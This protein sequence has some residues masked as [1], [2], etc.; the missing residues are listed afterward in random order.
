MIK[1]LI[2]SVI[3][4]YKYT[5]K[6]I[7]VWIATIVGFTIYKGY[8]LG[9]TNSMMPSQNNAFSNWSLRR[10]YVDKGLYSLLHLNIVSIMMATSLLLVPMI[11]Y[12]FIVK[13]KIILDKG[14]GTYLS[15]SF[16]FVLS[17]YTFM[18][19]DTP[20]NYYASRYFLFILVPLIVIL[21]IIILSKIKSKLIILLVLII[22]FSFN[23]TYDY[24]LY[25]K[26]VFQNGFGMAQ[27]I[28]NEI[29]DGSITFLA[30]DIFS[31]RLLVQ[32]LRYL[33][34]LDV[35]YLGKK[36]KDNLK[37]IKNK[38]ELY[39]KELNLKTVYLITDNLLNAR[40]YNKKVRYIS[41]RHPWSIIYPISTHQVNKHYYIYKFNTDEISR[42]KSKATTYYDIGNN[43]K[44]YI[45]HM[46][47]QE[48]KRLRWT[49]E[50][51]SVKLDYYDTA[52]D[53]KLIIRTLGERPK[54]NPANV[55]IYLNDKLIDDFIKKSGVLER[56]V[57]VSKSILNKDK[58]QV[59]IIKTNT[60]KPNN[61]G[62]K[63]N[64]ELGIQ[65]DWI[66]IEEK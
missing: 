55:E 57:D 13:P 11:F 50:V 49:K 44:I 32:S 45:N 37:I 3:L 65:L 41:S 66:K 38:L 33:D 31:K 35:I 43:D 21:S 18:R 34:D 62:S 10:L 36:S 42:L 52:K 15:Y 8:Q 5:S 22:I 60:W 29:P 54:D 64:R 25:K 30:S 47:G 12:F 61:Y 28:T 1:N 20:S 59:L 53:I 48:N 7:R 6:I 51:S 9:W 40:Q 23:L 17:I 4:D 46:Y 19:I 56:E 16:L 14:K 26:P 24:F 39:S 27:E 58:Q 63:D 2:N